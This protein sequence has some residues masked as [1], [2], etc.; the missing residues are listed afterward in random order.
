MQ[1]EVLSG[2]KNTFCT[3]GINDEVIHAAS[4]VFHMAVPSEQCL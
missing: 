4:Y 1:R 3:V 2:G